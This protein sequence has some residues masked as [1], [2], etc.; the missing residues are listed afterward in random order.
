MQ[1]ALI[2]CFIMHHSCAFAF[3]FSVVSNRPNL[4]ISSHS[5]FHCI[6]SLRGLS[7]P[8]WAQ[9]SF[10]FSVDQLLSL[11]NSFFFIS[12]ADTI[13]IPHTRIRSIG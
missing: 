13:Q 1:I 5:I 11:F 2:A 6:V 8:L 3:Y 7:G 4:F 10:A 12:I 9:E